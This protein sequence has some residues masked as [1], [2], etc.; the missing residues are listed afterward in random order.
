[1]YPG[2]RHAACSNDKAGLDDFFKMFDRLHIASAESKDEKFSWMWQ[3][4]G[5]DATPV[6]LVNG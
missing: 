1:V 6:R 3:L 4:F 2:N 5:L